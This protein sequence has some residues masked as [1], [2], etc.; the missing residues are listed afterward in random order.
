MFQ[1]NFDLVLAIIV[2]ESL[3]EKNKRCQKLLKLGNFIFIK[4]EGNGRREEEEEEGQSKKG[5]H[6]V[7]N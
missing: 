1:N 5:V 6:S 3:I 4:N 2:Q 7:Y